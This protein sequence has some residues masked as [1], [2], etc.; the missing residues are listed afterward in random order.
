MEFIKKRIFNILLFLSGVLMLLAPRILFPV[1]TGLNKMGYPMK[2]TYSA[3]LI[4][5]LGG[6]LALIALIAIFVNKRLV[7]ALAGLA[8]IAAASISYLIPMQVIKLGDMKKLHWE[9]GFCISPDMACLQ[10]TLPAL[11]VIL[12]VVGILGVVALVMAFLA[13]EN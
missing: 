8:A 11:K 6:L 9:V 1:C 2:C 12:P 7:S 4:M 5:A 10:N 13:S 3:T